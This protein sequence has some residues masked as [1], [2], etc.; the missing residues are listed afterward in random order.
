MSMAEVRRFLVSGKVQGV[1]FR[2]ST[3]REAQR[4]KLRG[5]ALNLPD[6]RV[7]VLA[8]GGVEDLAQLRRWLDHGPPAARVDAVE[9]SL[10]DAAVADALSGFRTG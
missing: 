7:E 1:F 4:L 3:A 10:L 2:A 9:E 5:H 8:A 6:G